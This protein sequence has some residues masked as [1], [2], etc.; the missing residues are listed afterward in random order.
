MCDS[1]VCIEILRQHYSISEEKIEKAFQSAKRSVV[2]AQQLQ[3]S[4]KSLV[5][6]IREVSE[7]VNDLSEHFIEEFSKE[8][9]VF[10]RSSLL[11]CIDSLCQF[12]DIID[13][14]LNKAFN[15]K[16]K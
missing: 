15:T 10:V 1:L 8:Q 14:E 2:P 12:Y 4:E 9:M 6:H 3:N 16:V 5:L 11:V 7:I 13:G